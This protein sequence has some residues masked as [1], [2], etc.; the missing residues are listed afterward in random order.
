MARI[1]NREESSREIRT[2]LP[3]S[4]SCGAVSA[5]LI[6]NVQQVAQIVLKIYSL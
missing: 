3:G 2:R 4:C 1:V 6:K 5:A